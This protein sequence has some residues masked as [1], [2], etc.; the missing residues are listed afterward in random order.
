MK[1]KNFIMMLSLVFGLILTSC[2][3]RD[4]IE[5]KKTNI[6]DVNNIMK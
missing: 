5:K 1:K 2:T 6:E 4:S 3:T